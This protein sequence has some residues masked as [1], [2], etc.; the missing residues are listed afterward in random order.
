MTK[1]KILII[2]DDKDT[3]YTFQ[4]ICSFAEWNPILASDGRQ[5]VQLYLS[6]NPDLIL[7][8]YHMPEMNGLQ[9]LKTIRQMDQTVP[10]MVLTVDERQSL[11]DQFLA[12]GANDFALKPIKA[13][14]MISRIKVHLRMVAMSE[15]NTKEEESEP[16]DEGS[17]VQFESLLSKGI[18][19]QTLEVILEYLESEARPITIEQVSE[20]TGISYA[21]V[22][23]YLN[24]L[25]QEGVVKTRMDY[26]SVGRPKNK[27][28]RE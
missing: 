11:A 15:Q 8:D 7:I 17:T 19:K 23:R 10:V 28:I 6:E 4:E 12:A 24:H 21:T 1:K 14:D 2:D 27:Y 3:R 5:G 25:L 26:G 9:T 18:S 20:G 22:H 13:I 16:Q